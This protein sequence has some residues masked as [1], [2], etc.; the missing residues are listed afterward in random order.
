MISIYE[1]KFEG[2]IVFVPLLLEPLQVLA[3]ELDRDP[4]LA[5]VV[6]DVARDERASGVRNAAKMAM[7]RYRATRG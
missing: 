1:P 4:A 3:R 7:E 2:I 6:E 5:S